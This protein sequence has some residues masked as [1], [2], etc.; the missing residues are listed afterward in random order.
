MVRL[1]TTRILLTLAAAGLAFPSA[2]AAQLDLNITALIKADGEDCDVAE[3]VNRGFNAQDC[4]S[5]TA[6]VDLRPAASTMVTGNMID[7]WMTTGTGDC[8]TTEARNPMSATCQHVGCY[9]LTDNRFLIPLADIDA[10]AANPLCESSTRA[11]L[12]VSLTTFAGAG[13]MNQDA[14][15]A[16]ATD[17]V[18]VRVDAVGPVAPPLDSTSVAGDNEVD[19]SW[20]RDSE[21]N[22]RFRL[23]YGGACSGAAGDGGTTTVDPGSLTFIRETDLMNSSA[24]LDPEADLGLGVGEEVGVYVAGVD[25]AGNEGEL[26][27]PICVSRIDAVGFCD[28]FDGCE[29]GCSAGPVSGAGF[30]SFFLLALVV[31]RRRR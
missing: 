17:S 18:S 31:L 2:G 28:D 4:A 24:T 14:V 9:D 22:L 13:C 7:V 1:P 11:G 26:A 21:A 30:G 12:A 27:G 10:A 5:T 3:C 23:Y 29:E 20:E 25:V 6:G 8:S 15:D 19:I 16:D